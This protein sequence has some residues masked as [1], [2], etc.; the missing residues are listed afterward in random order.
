MRQVAVPLVLLCSFLLCFCGNEK[1]AV[2]ASREVKPDEPETATDSILKFWLGK[3]AVNSDFPF[4]N[5]LWFWTNWQELDSIDQQKTLLRTAVPK[6]PAEKICDQFLFDKK[7]DAHPVAGWLRSGA[8]QRRRDAWPCYWAIIPAA[9]VDSFAPPNQLV[10]VVL[11]DS[12][13]VVVFRPEGREAFNVFDM[14]GKLVPLPEAEK[15]RSRIAM[16]FLQSETAQG[17]FRS[18]YLCNEKMIRSWHHGVPGVQDKVAMDINYMM[19]L[20]AW[21]EAHREKAILP[22]Q[23]VAPRYWTG[24]PRKMSIA[25]LIGSTQRTAQRDPED[26]FY[27]TK[28]SIDH[29]RQSWRLQLHPMERYPSRG[30]R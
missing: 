30:A 15:S 24:N 3:Q 4:P 2:A 29:I 28:T 20:Y 5:T 26:L 11:E 8:L 12:A 27:Y 13:L 7:W 18:F 6:T 1:K 25:E 17:S 10:Q 19:L 16:I 23:S 14:Q 9:P 22:G 21:Q